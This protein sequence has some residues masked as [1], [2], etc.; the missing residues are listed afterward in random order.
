MALTAALVDKARVINRRDA[1]RVVE[2]RRITVPEQG[3]WF[4][5]RL[6]PAGSAEDT[7]DGRVAYRNRTTLLVGVRDSSGQKI[8]IRG[9][10][11]LEV[12]SKELGHARWQVTGDPKPIRKRRTILGWR[13][14][15]SKLEEDRAAA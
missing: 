8:E 9:S 12:D 13:V 2:G 3:P 7:D 15:V 1:G 5:C 11:Q 4:R 6:R 10:D 14:S